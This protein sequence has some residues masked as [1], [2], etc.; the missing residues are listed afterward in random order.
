MNYKELFDRIV[1]LISSPAKAWEE[2][3]NETD[4]QKVMNGFVYLMI[5]LCGLAVFIGT[6]FGNSADANEAFTIAMRNCCSTF[7]SL[8]GGFFLSA[9]LSN[10]VGKKLLNRTEEIELNRQF[11]GYAMVV[12]FVLEIISGLFS[13]S[14]LHWILQFY[15][16]FVVY[17]GARTLMKVD[18]QD[19]TRYS[20]IISLFIIAC[21][22]IISFLFAKLSLILN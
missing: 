9:Y 15:T 10:E 19:L 2:I 21:P 1:V 13:I 3:T 6:F 4:K 16:V 7:I 17:E 22:A 14:L 11:V 5:G 8:F 20:L 18:E 12:V